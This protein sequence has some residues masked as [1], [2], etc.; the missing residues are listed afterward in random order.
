MWM[1]E[2]SGISGGKGEIRR[3]EHDLA[4][5]IIEREGYMNEFAKSL[6]DAG[7]QFRFRIK[8]HES[9]ATGAKQLAAE[10]SVLHC[11]LIDI[12]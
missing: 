9:A 2:E 1:G 3:V 11:Y 10:G 5:L 8:E 7:L 4:A 6:F 12:I